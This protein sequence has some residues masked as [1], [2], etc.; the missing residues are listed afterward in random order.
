MLNPWTLTEYLEWLTEGFGTVFLGWAEWLS[1]QAKVILGDN[2]NFVLLL[3]VACL[4]GIAGA[5]LLMSFS[6]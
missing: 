5:L 2:V 1:K 6:H 3:V 4:G